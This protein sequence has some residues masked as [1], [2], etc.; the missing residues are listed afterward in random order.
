MDSLS[1]ACRCRSLY[2]PRINWPVN[3][4]VI[5]VAVAIRVSD[6]RQSRR[7]DGGGAAQSRMALR[8]NVP[9]SGSKMPLCIRH[10]FFLALWTP[11]GHSSPIPLACSKPT[12]RPETRQGT[13]DF[14][15][16]PHSQKCQTL[17]VLRQ[18]RRV[19]FWTNGWRGY[20]AAL[21][22]LDRDNRC[23]RRATNTANVSGRFDWQ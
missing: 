6:L 16:C 1:K 11:C 13:P 22:K 5:P 4:S 10:R 15:P 14:P 19:S 17:Q 18:S 23:A 3:V 7:L 2:S 8:A 21:H 9:P 20:A 12:S